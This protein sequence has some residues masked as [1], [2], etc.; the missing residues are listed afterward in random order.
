M[1]AVTDYTGGTGSAQTTRLMLLS[2]APWI[3]QGEQVVL[4]QQTRGRI[5]PAR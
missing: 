4:R 5:S 1:A 3:I 2:T